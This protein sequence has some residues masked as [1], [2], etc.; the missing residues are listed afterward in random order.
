M[1]GTRVHSPWFFGQVSRVK[2]PGERITTDAFR[3]IL[4]NGPIIAESTWFRR[5]ACV[6]DDSL[7]RVAGNNRQVKGHR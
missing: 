5:G 7:S 4:H 1:F 2:E 6:H 3:E